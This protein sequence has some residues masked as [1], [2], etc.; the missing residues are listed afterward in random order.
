MHNFVKLLA[1]IRVWFSHQ[2]QI[3][4]QS[5]SFHENGKKHQQAVE[6]RLYEI[7][8]KGKKDDLKARKEEEW[9]KE[10]ERKAMNDYRTKDVGNNADITAKIFNQKRQELYSRD[11]D[12]TSD[13]AMVA[14]QLAAMDESMDKA[15]KPGYVLFIFSWCHCEWL[16]NTLK[17]G[18]IWKKIYYRT[19]KSSIGPSIGPQIEVPDAFKEVAGVASD[20]WDG[21]VI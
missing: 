14:A 2:L 15:G 7:K 18:I 6:N 21:W 4:F 1:Y 5:I 9:M 20:K 11:D 12:P 16:E 13:K 19:S 10:I 3:L 17:F 8:R